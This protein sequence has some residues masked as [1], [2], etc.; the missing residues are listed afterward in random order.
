MG[1]TPLLRPQPGGSAVAVLG[2]HQLALLN[3]HS[4]LSLVTGLVA[5]PDLLSKRSKLL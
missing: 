2:F 3:D 4:L 1:C 5:L